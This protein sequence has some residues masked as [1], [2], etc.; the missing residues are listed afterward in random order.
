MRWR[1]AGA[2]GRAGLWLESDKKE[3]KKRSSAARSVRSFATE[4]KLDPDWNVAI[5]PLDPA[6]R[7]LPSQRSAIARTARELTSACVASWPAL[8]ASQ[9]A[10]ARPG[11]R[12]RQR[13]ALPPQRW[14]RGTT[15]PSLT[16][17]GA[18]IRGERDSCRQ[19]ISPGIGGLPPLRRTRQ[20][21][22]LPDSFT[23]ARS[24]SSLH[25]AIGSIET[26]SKRSEGTP[27]DRET[28]ALRQRNRI[29]A[30]LQL[31]S[32]S[33]SLRVRLLQKVYN[34]VSRLSRLFVHDKV[35]CALDASGSR[36]RKGAREEV[37]DPVFLKDRAALVGKNKVCG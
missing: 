14:R 5:V 9:S 1:L 15:L 11:C 12:E 25:N 4:R 17:Y 23:A 6:R 16:A 21:R 2:K 3:S 37:V 33:R 35:T 19:R 18:C 8:P 22:R 29:P 36:V 20:A 32:S 27:R 13:T 7:A 34:Q 31:R 28:R 10:C 24:C 26:A 30:V